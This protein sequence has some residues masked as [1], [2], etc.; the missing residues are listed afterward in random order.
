MSKESG[1]WPKETAICLECGAMDGTREWVLGDGTCDI[2]HG[3]TQTVPV[4]PASIAA[5]LA[6]ALE[7]CI[8]LASEGWDYASPYFREKWDCEGE[9][10]KARAAL[11]K[12][13]AALGEEAGK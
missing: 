5:D 4:L 9:I 10:E 7:E 8:Q 13:H 2:G 6:E 12:Y 11:T 3:P 1:V